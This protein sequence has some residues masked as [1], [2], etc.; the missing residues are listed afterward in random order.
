MR[1]LSKK[2][3]RIRQIGNETISFVIIKSVRAVRLPNYFLSRHNQCERS[4]IVFFVAF[5]LKIICFQLCIG[6]VN[7]YFV[8]YLMIL[9]LQY[10][11]TVLG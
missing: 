2:C 5:S 1:C 11:N 7:F 6:D 9:G 3:V 4:Y 8:C 10:F